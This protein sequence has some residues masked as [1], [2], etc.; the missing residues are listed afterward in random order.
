[1]RWHGSVEALGREALAAI[2][3]AL[4]RL[5]RDEVPLRG[6]DM[7]GLPA[8][9]ALLRP[10]AAPA[11]PAS[12]TGSAPPPDLP[13][14]DRMVEALAAKGTGLRGRLRRRLG[15]PRAMRCISAPRTRPRIST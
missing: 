1:M 6:F 8:L 12:A 14:L 4:E 5:P 10:E 3:D 15:R 9:R 7:V 11:A 2:P 13:G